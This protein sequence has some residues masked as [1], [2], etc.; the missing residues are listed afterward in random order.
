M[1]IKRAV[2]NLVYKRSIDQKLFEITA[3]IA[4]DMV[5]GMPISEKPDKTETESTALDFLLAL[6]SEDVSAY[7]SDISDLRREFSR[8]ITRRDSPAKSELWSIV[9]AALLSLEKAGKVFR[10]KAYRRFSNNNRTPWFLKGNEGKTPDWNAESIL[11]KN[12]PRLRGKREKDKI[13]S[14][15]E[16]CKMVTTVLKTMNG[17]I[18]MSR[19]FE[20]IKANVPLFSVSVSLDAGIQTEDSSLDMYERLESSAVL[21]DYSFLINEERDIAVSH[22]WKEA[23]AV[24]RGTGSGSLI[25]GAK[26]LC[27][28]V[29]PKD[30]FGTKTT[31]DKFGPTSTVQDVAKDLRK[32][33]AKWMPAEKKPGKD[34]LENFIYM[35]TVGAILSALTDLC[36]ENN[37]CR[38]FY[39]SMKQGLSR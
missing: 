21:S 39:D 23:S 25:E 19:I 29:L 9:S 11:S 16:A 3:K 27:C 5:S 38:S 32:I 17:E 33:L 2:T 14:P 18:S 8:W 10:P 4:A 28:Y 31:L 34:T 37:L 1:D 12:M 13:L 6:A 22:I 26:I 7:I 24:C 20:L 15:E 35:E 36:S 30:A